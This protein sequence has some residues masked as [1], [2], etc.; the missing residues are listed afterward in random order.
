MRRIMI[1]VLAAA[2]TFA[3]AIPAGAP[4]R[5]GGNE[6]SSAGKCTAA[7]TSKIKVKPDNGRL[8]VEFEVDQNRSGVKWHVRLKDNSDVVF[9]GSATTQPPSGSFSVEKKINNRA[10]SD[11]I[12]GI[13]RNRQSGERCVAS[14]TI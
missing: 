3:L 14:V 2:A 9:R 12:V 6:V 1:S 4:A 5:G 8:D 11:R 10:G 7:S 13:G